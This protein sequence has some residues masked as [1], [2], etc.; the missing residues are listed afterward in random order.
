MFDKLSKLFA[1]NPLNSDDAS[2]RLD[3]VNHLAQPDTPDEERSKQAALLIELASSDSDVAVRQ[4]AIG[5]V[6]DATALK[7]LLDDAAV[8]QQA[9][10][11]LLSLD[12]RRAPDH[13]MLRHVIAL[14]SA[15]GDEIG[16]AI[17]AMPVSER[18]R[19][20]LAHPSVDARMDIARSLR[21][22]EALHELELASRDGDKTL[23]RL[24]RERLDQLKSASASVA[25]GCSEIERLCASLGVHKQAAV[26]GNW[27]SKLNG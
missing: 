25:S 12:S 9:A 16:A 20:A 14:K 26:D 23:N 8:A 22:G 17:E 13:P 11:T 24:A 1:G 19:A 2:V 10:Q 27:L 7:P 4:A 18:I 21:T 15:A 3:G 5:L 6:T